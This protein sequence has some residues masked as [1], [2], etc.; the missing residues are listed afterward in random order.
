MSRFA[1]AR[2]AQSAARKLGID[3]VPVVVLDHL[4]PAQRRAYVIADKTLACNAISR[5]RQAGALE[6]D[7]LRAF[8]E[9]VDEPRYRGCPCGRGRT[10]SDRETANCTAIAL[11]SNMAARIDVKSDE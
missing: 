2:V 3:T 11:F 10:I 4:T 8:D 7:E 1:L 5:S 6:R 9:I